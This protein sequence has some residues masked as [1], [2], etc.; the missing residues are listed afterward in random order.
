MKLIEKGTFEGE[1]SLFKS[2]NTEI[3]DSVFLEG[4]SPIKEKEYII[5]NFGVSIQ[6]GIIKM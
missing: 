6:Y 2:F 1:R 4:E 5:V 3:K